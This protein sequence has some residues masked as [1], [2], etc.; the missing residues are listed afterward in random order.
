MNWTCDLYRSKEGKRRE[1]PA[2]TQPKG[3]ERNYITH[4]LIVFVP[5]VMLNYSC[6]LNSTCCI[7]EHNHAY[8]QRMLYCTI[9]HCKSVGCCYHLASFVIVC[10]HTTL[11]LFVYIFNDEWAQLGSYEKALD[12]V[13]L[14]MYYGWHKF[15]KR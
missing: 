11:S 7:C 13:I 12:F 5:V 2:A 6:V 9:K 1:K 14:E 10:I 15:G 3:N 8:H 4:I